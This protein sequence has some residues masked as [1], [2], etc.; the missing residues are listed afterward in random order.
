[1]LEA[2]WN[3]SIMAEAA[4]KNL[5]R[6]FAHLFLSLSV[7][8]IAH[9][10]SILDDLHK[11]KNDNRAKTVFI[12][13]YDQAQSG[14]LEASGTGVLLKSG[15]V[16]TSLHL[17]AD[18]TET[19]F[20]T[21]LPQ[22]YVTGIV[23]ENE[24]IQYK[25]TYIDQNRAQ[26]IVLLR[27]GPSIS[28][29]NDYACISDAV[30]A[31]GDP[32]GILGFPG[33]LSLNGVKGFVSGF[34]ASSILLDVTVAKGFSGAGVYNSQGEIVGIVKGGLIS[35]GANAG[36]AFIVPIGFARNL[37]AYVPGGGAGCESAS[38]DLMNFSKFVRLMAPR[39]AV[40][41]GLGHPKVSTRS[42]P[43]VDLPSNATAA[44]EAAVEA[45]A[46]KMELPVDLYVF[47]DFAS[48]IAYSDNS[49]TQ[50]SIIWR[51]DKHPLDLSILPET[52]YWDNS[53]NFKDL[54]IGNAYFAQFTEE[55]SILSG[56]YWQSDEWTKLTCQ[57]S[58]AHG[59]I[60]LAFAW[61]WR[62][63]RYPSFLDPDPDSAKNESSGE[64]PP[65]GDKGALLAYGPMGLF[66]MSQVSNSLIDCGD[67]ATSPITTEAEALAILRRHNVETRKDDDG[68]SRDL[69]G[70][71][72]KTICISLNA[73]RPNTVVVTGADFLSEEVTLSTGETVDLNPLP[74]GV[75]SA[76]LF[77]T[78]ASLAFSG[79]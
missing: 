18:L 48:E 64:G 37:L 68:I 78:G 15:F 62:G 24:G 54:K 31:D 59:G 49:V 47:P 57:T 36:F 76:M 44:D 60:G 25:L 13:V 11:F 2:G 75:A 22:K 28:Q 3:F 77:G 8:N 61:T 41:A 74:D 23:G 32:V 43:Q 35:G 7:L 26:D 79:D 58:E 4:I 9:G 1:M 42:S 38:N 51:N 50:Y 29:N 12:Q 55:C 21:T 20:E 39:E 71:G 34:E 56:D 14:T 46:K 17:V 45:A 40:V 69:E 5:F 33:G 70:N 65:T 67:F 16:L 30:P 19:D 52:S 6:L 10:A 53:I 73:T 27:F 66:Q 72:S 63:A